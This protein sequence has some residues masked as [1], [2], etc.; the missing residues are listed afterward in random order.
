MS[1][2]AMVCPGGPGRIGAL[3][4]QG[5]NLSVPWTACRRT[6]R[7]RVRVGFTLI[8]CLLAMV[9]LCV[10]IM[11]VVEAQ[12]Y[13]MRANEFSSGAATA[14]YLAGEV[15]EKMRGLPKHD[16]VDGLYLDGANLVGWGGE[17]GEGGVV[18]FDDVDDFDGKVFGGGQAGALPGPVDA[19]G[20]VINQV[21]F[22]GVVEQESG[23]PVPMRGWRQQ[24]AVVKVEP[25]DYST[26]RANNYQRLTT[27]PRLVVAEFA[28]RVTVTV[29]Y[30]GPL[31]DSP[32]TMATLSWVVP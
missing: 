30:Q 32:R 31:D 28:L 26:V 29:T 13:F 4:C 25:T 10:G 6:R 11:A 19:R 2:P 24:V 8:E 15:R 23:N 18:D 7:G 9:I 14:G 5:N 21:D 27:A 12:A 20:R 16:P 17:P 22:N 3:I 1:G